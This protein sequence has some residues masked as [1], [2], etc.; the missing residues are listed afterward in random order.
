MVDKYDLRAAVQYGALHYLLDGAQ[1]L[2]VPEAVDLL[3]NGLEDM[4]SAD[5][6][7]LIGNPMFIG[8]AMIIA[9]NVT[10]GR[11]GVLQWNRETYSY[12][13]IDIDLD[14]ETEN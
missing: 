3:Y 7:L 10:N 11:F 4:S 2:D 14:Y 13:P 1:R 12:L 6:L 5:R 8:L 9:G